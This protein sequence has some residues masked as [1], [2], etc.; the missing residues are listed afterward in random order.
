MKFFTLLLA[1]GLATG[2]GTDASYTRTLASE[3]E[4]EQTKEGNRALKIAGIAAGVALGCVI[5]GVVKNKC[6]PFAK[7]V[8]RKVEDGTTTK[9][10]GPSKRTAPEPSEVSGVKSKQD[11]GLDLD[12]VQKKMDD[13][14][15]NELVEEYRKLYEAG[16]ISK[17][18]F[19]LIRDRKKF[20][21]YL[22]ELG[23]GIDKELEQIGEESAEKAAIRNRG[24]ELHHM[25]T[26]RAT[27]L[28]DHEYLLNLQREGKL[29]ELAVYQK[30]IARKATDELVQ[31]GKMTVE[32]TETLSK[33]ITTMNMN[34]ASFIE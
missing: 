18:E 31:E 33:Y 32:D 27:E 4:R 15:Y 21:R 9:S 10:V 30:D 22:E 12:N 14:G 17:E 8:A 23:E 2:C 11:D 19:D 7:K 29:D 24:S 16:E 26:Q 6:I 20:E 28:A 3:E 1:L 5:A 34:G 13:E 25:R